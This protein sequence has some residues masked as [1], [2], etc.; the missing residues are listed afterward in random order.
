MIVKVK[1]FGFGSGEE[2][3]PCKESLKNQTQVRHILQN[4]AALPAV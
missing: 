3:K 1:R 2:I 4:A